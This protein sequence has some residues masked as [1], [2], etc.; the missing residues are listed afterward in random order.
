MVESAGKKSLLFKPEF[1][2]IE[3]LKTVQSHEIG[4]IIHATFLVYLHN[5]VILEPWFSRD[6]SGDP[7][8]GVRVRPATH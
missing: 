5:F 3:N 4:N 7:I 1:T 2:V 6:F 8:I